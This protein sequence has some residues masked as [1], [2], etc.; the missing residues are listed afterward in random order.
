ME[1]LEKNLKIVIPTD[2]PD[3]VGKISYLKK[4]RNTIV[5]RY[6]AIGL[7]TIAIIIGGFWS[8]LELNGLKFI[9]GKNADKVEKMRNV[10]RQ[11]NETSSLSEFDATNAFMNILKYK[12][13]IERDP[14][15]SLEDFPSIDNNF[16]SY[17][18][19][20]TSIP[21]Y[22]K[23]F[24][25]SKG[26]VTKTKNINH[27]KLPAAWDS[28]NKS[29]KQ[30]AYFLNSKILYKLNLNLENLTIGSPERIENESDNTLVSS[31]EPFF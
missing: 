20:Y 1:P 2:D 19:N 11:L 18:S 17:I 31:F 7:V 13:T 12:D 9:N 3:Y 15:I 27:F 14:M 25:I 29:L 6:L 16:H 21:F 22:S 8:V 10:L 26:S 5:M 30:K 24:D 4:A 28:W 23:T